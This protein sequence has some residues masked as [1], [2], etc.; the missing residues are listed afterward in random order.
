MKRPARDLNRWSQRLGARTLTTTPPSPLVRSK[1]QWLKEGKKPT[2]YFCN[3]ENKYFVEKTVKKLQKGS[4][5]D[6]AKR[7]T[8]NYNKLLCIFISE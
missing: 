5:S 2:R 4:T 8:K 3:L 1:L 7:N 6:R